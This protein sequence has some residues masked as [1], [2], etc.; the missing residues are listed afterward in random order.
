MKMNSMDILLH[1]YFDGDLS[2]EESEA[3]LDDV[4][5]DPSLAAR[6]QME[7]HL[8][9]AIIDDAYS[10]DPPAHIRKAVLGAIHSKQPKVGLYREWLSVGVVLLACMVSAIFPPSIA[11]H[12]S[13]MPPVHVGLSSLVSFDHQTVSPPPQSL[14]TFHHTIAIAAKP[15]SSRE[16]KEATIHTGDVTSVRNVA[17]P[18]SI[19]PVAIPSLNYPDPEN[20]EFLS[21]NTAFPFLE[22]VRGIGSSSNQALRMHAATATPVMLF[23]EIGRISIA[24]QVPLFVNGVAAEGQESISDVYAAVGATYSIT[25]STLNDR[26]L[27]F[28]AAVGASRIG[29]LGLA[30]VTIDILHIQGIQLQAGLRWMGVLSTQGNGIT[31]PSR[32]EPVVGLQMNF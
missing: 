15:P 7:A 32:L 23:A 27:A 18:S 16:N 22:G 13:G 26:E 6:V 11:D 24:Q 19:R 21:I 28:S 4:A 2:P 5:S 14:T 3:F 29:A 12:H 8:D 30:D 20:I 1:R 10:L 9:L 17:L 25:L 31:I